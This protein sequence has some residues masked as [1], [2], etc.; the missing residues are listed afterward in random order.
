[1]QDSDVAFRRVVTEMQLCWPERLR[2]KATCLERQ[3]PEGK[4]LTDM[5]SP[6]ASRME[7]SPTD[8]IQANES[9]VGLLATKLSKISA[10]F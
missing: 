4:K 7:C 5:D 6:L 1:M 10:M 3:L 2:E 8:R 9:H